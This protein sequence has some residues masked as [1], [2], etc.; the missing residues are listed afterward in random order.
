MI[1]AGQNT[2][3][4]TNRTLVLGGRIIDLR[5]PRV[6]GIINVTPDSFYRDS[7][8][9]AEFEVL[10]M[11]E[12]MIRDGADIV[13]IGGYSS[14]P[15][16]NEITEAEELSRVLPAIRAV[17]KEFPEII[18]SVDTFR[19]VVAKQSVEAGAQIV[20]DISGGDLDP[21][22]HATA[23]TLRV[24]YVIM[25]MKG[26][27]Q[28]M[29]TH[30]QYEDLLKEV[31]QHL[32]SKVKKLNDHG[33]HDILIDPG[34][35]FA[36]SP[37]Q[38]FAL[39]EALPYLRVIGRP[40]LVGVS[41]KSLIWKTLETSPED[42]LTG[43]N[44]LNTVALLKGASVLRVHDVKEAVEGVKLLRYLAVNPAASA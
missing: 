11:A 10:G 24:P 27:P 36:K 28:T 9:S 22:M 12:K 25:H 15:G 6:M 41:R 31:V 1:F 43:T 32:Q 29:A 30:T 21:G 23:T 16:A 38:N 19:A 3:F 40:I 13:D 26:D 37:A 42:A 20:N 34:V 4:S 33:L 44:V 17:R 35:G 14:R 7:R 2:A 18:V 8:A 5:Y 39:L